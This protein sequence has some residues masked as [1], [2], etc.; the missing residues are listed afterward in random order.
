MPKQTLIYCRLIPTLRKT[1]RQGRYWKSGVR[2][3]LNWLKKDCVTMIFCDGK[4]ERKSP[5]LFMACIFLEQ[6]SMIWIKM[7]NWILL[8][9]K[10]LHQPKSPVS[11]IRN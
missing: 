4:K 10:A 3:A 6:V 11:N 9:M 1:D 2:D 5:N 8:F 7:A